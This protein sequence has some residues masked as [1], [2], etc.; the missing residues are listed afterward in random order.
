MYTNLVVNGDVMKDLSRRSF[1]GHA[2]ALT[3]GGILAPLHLVAATPKFEVVSF[4]GIQHSHPDAYVANGF[5]IPKMSVGK[6][7]HDHA[8]YFDSSGFLCK[9]VYAGAWAV[10]AVNADIKV[11]SSFNSMPVGQT[12]SFKWKDH[13]IVLKRT[14]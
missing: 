14:S 1:L 8:G 6:C 7:D 12:R 5:V 11:P 4:R 9:G 10:G 3:A 2:M 13:R